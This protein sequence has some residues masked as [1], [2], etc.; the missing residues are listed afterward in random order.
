VNKDLRRDFD[1][2]IRE[3]RFMVIDLDD[4]AAD[5]LADESIPESLAADLESNLFD[6]AADLRL[7]INDLEKL[8]P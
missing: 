1:R 5:S 2:T 6:A 4:L 8:L 7:V 3:M